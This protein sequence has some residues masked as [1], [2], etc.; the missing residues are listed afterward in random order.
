[1]LLLLASASA[2]T[3]TKYITGGL[4]RHVAPPLRLDVTMTTHGRN[5]RRSWLGGVGL[6]VF[7]SAAPSPAS[8]NLVYFREASENTVAARLRKLE[9]VLDDLQRDI[10]ARDWEFIVEYPGQIKAFVPAFTRY[11]DKAFPDDTEI[12]KSLR[13]AMR[14]EVG[15]LYVAVEKLRK[16]GKAKDVVAA[17]AAFAD[18][19]LA[20]DRYLKS[21]N[22]YDGADK[23]LEGAEVD[24]PV[25]LRK[26]KSKQPQVNTP[27]PSK[28]SKAAL[29]SKPSN[30]VVTSPPLEAKTVPEEEKKPVAKASIE[31]Q[32]STDEAPQIGEQVVAIE[33]PDLGVTGTLLGISDG[34]TAIIK[35]A[36]VSRGFREIVTRPLKSVAKIT[37]SVGP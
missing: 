15:K 20:Y 22:L 14:Y 28:P 31:V 21:G 1:M 10:A 30:E 36:K 12:D 27:P 2:F 34:I 5:S 33:E 24:V 35:T 4:Q 18:I 7:V 19:S 32:Y 16:A 29:D 25:K 3:S 8:A 11:T 17:Q 9:A 26:V 23:D 37:N 13:F 6:T